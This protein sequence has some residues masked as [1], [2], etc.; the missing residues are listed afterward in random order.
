MWS[1]LPKSKVGDHFAVIEKSINVAETGD[2]T[3]GIISKKI[4]SQHLN[5]TPAK[6]IDDFVNNLK[7]FEDINV[8]HGGPSVNNFPKAPTLLCVINTLGRHQHLNCNIILNKNNTSCIK[9]K[10]L[11]KVWCFVV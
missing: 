1:L 8:C 4:D 9:C 11:R 10:K 7:K 3:I 5:I 2:V 6:T